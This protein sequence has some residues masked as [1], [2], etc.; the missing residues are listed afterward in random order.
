[1]SAS[2][3]IEHD[4]H[5][6]HHKNKIR[7]KTHL[8]QGLADCDWLPISFTQHRLVFSRWGQETE[9]ETASPTRLT[10]GWT[11][12][13]L[14]KKKDWVVISTHTSTSP[15]TTLLLL[16]FHTFQR[17]PNRLHVF[18]QGICQNTWI[19]LSSGSTLK[20]WRSECETF[21]MTKSA[22]VS[23]VIG[24]LINLRI[25]V[26]LKVMETF[27][28]A[29]PHP[30]RFTAFT[31]CNDIHAHLQTMNRK[32]SFQLCLKELP[33]FFLFIILFIYFIY[34]KVFKHFYHKEKC[35]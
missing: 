4:S 35:K 25:S 24:D 1:M 8:A 23:A 6:F 5:W 16:L 34:W 9:G 14:H 22:L 2:A 19:Y 18:M 21:L 15:F 32:W 27:F 12:S 11:R 29:F 17:R 3:G 13:P 20:E 33:I 31:K 10:R 28:L 7:S 30:Y 26:F